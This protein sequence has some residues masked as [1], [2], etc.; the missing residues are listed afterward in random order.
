MIT[1]RLD[2]ASPVPATVVR[3]IDADAFADTALP[4]QGE[5]GA[6][7]GLWVDSGTSVRD[8]KS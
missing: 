1:G 8:G 4:E 7:V 2:I 5:F 3:L 6:F